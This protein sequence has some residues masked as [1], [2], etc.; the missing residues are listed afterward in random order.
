VGHAVAQW[1]R[2]YTATRRKVAGSGHDEENSSIYIILPVALGPGVYSPY[3]RNECYKH[4]IVFLGSILP[5]VRKLTNLP[6]SASRLST[7][8]GILNSKQLK[9]TPRPVTWI[10]LLYGDGV[11]FL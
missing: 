3:K 11:C 7:Q 5:P 2:Q 10:A 4:K 8:C 9:R 6:P 1:L